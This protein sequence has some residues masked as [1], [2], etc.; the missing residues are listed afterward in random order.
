LSPFRHH[1]GGKGALWQSGNRILIKN[2]RE[3][4]CEK[5]GLGLVPKE[6]FGDFPDKQNRKVLRDRLSCPYACNV[7]ISRLAQ[8]KK[9][10]RKSGQNK[11]R[12]P[13]KN[14]DGRVE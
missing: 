8:V 10:A 13:R 5:E 6:G 14:L 7:L 9:Q 1:Y 11:K 2:F 12:P 4:G 3:Y